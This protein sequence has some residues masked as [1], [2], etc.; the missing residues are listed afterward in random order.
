LAHTQGKRHQTNLAKRAAREAKDAPTKPQPLKRNVS[1]RRT[2]NK[3]FY[4]YLVFCNYNTALFP[5][6]ISNLPRPGIGYN[7]KV[8]V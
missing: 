1:V 4:V 6:L 8:I 2:G 5:L 7:G 3:L